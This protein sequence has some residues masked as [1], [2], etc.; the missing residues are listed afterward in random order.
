MGTRGECA[1]SPTLAAP[2]NTALRVFTSLRETAELD[3]EETN[4]S[5][6][7]DVLRDDFHGVDESVGRTQQDQ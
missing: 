4:A 5:P 2:G 6:T 7:Y 3:T 1:V